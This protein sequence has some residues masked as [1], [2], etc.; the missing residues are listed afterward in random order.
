LVKTTF[1]LCP[2]PSG[3]QTRKRP[4][5][6]RRE[7]PRDHC[8]SILKGSNIYPSLQRHFPCARRVE[9]KAALMG[10]RFFEY[11]LAFKKYC[12]AA[13]SGGKVVRWTIPRIVQEKPPFSYSFPLR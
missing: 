9:G 8:P 11:F 2:I 12:L 13:A 4:W 1:D 3:G 5:E 10:R 7:R 6:V